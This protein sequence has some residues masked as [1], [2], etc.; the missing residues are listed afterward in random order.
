MLSL[1]FV[2]IVIYVI[3]F[4]GLWKNWRRPVV[5]ATTLRDAFELLES[6]IHKAFPDLPEGFTWGEAISRARGLE[7]KKIDWYEL[8]RELRKYESQ[9]Y[10]GQVVTKFSIREILKL[11]MYLPRGSR[12][13]SR[14]KIKSYQ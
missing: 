3:F 10:G 14:S 6:S 11:V 2:N 7:L 9:R 12:F 13:G 4:V 1:L 8:E 5:K